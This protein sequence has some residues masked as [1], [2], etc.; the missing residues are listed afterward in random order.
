MP[1]KPK[2]YTVTVSCSLAAGRYRAGTFFPHGSGQYELT[3][4]QMEAVRAD[5]VLALATAEDEAEAAAG[6]MTAALDTLDANG[7]Y[8]LLVDVAAAYNAKVKAGDMRGEFARLTFSTEEPQL[9]AP[10]KTQKGAKAGQQETPKGNT[11]AEA[12]KGQE[13]AKAGQ[14]G[15]DKA[16][17]E[18]E[19]PNAKPDPVPEGFPHAEAFAGLPLA[20][21][22]G[23][24]EGGTLAAFPGMTPA[25]AAEVAEALE[26]LDSAKKGK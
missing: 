18:A 12:P 22:R 19:D 21:V 1:K 24:V 14:G 7:L 8:D 4:E 13:G 10:P 20:D 26:V 11:K 17:G 23:M 3:A 2:L 15:K 5:P 9:P 25:K 6:Q 16:K